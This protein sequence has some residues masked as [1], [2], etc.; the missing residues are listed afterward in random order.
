MR[1]LKKKWKENE[2]LFYLFYSVFTF[3]ARRQ[4]YV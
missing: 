1:N 2:I 3:K 4:K